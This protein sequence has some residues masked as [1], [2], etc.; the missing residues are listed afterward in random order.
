MVPIYAAALAITHPRAL[1]QL[2][3]ADQDRERSSSV[4]VR[5]VSRGVAKV[6]YGLMV[7]DLALAETAHQKNLLT[8]SMV[9]LL[10]LG[11]HLSHLADDRVDNR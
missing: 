4:R 9:F 6:R 2:H 10:N 3:R 5:N 7:Q 11:Q 8:S 1:P